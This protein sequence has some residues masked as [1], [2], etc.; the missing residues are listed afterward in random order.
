MVFAG[1]IVIDRGI[2]GG[3]PTSNMH[4]EL[5]PCESCPTSATVVTV[6]IGTYSAICLFH[7]PSLELKLT[8][9]ISI[10]KFGVSYRLDIPRARFMATIDALPSTQTSL[11]HRLR[12]TR[13]RKPTVHDDL[14]IVEQSMDD[15]QCVGTSHQS[16]FLGE[17]I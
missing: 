12:A 2:R 10:G 11:F 15:V 5:V 8:C 17:S 7:P 9:A 16:L 13:V 14:Q 1:N 6:N 3:E 4:L